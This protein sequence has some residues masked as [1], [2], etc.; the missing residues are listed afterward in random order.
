MTATEKRGALAVATSAKEL[1]NNLKNQAIA[2]GDR[3]GTDI[4]VGAELESRR[5]DMPRAPFIRDMDEVTALPGE[6][7][8]ERYTDLTALQV[9]AE[10]TGSRKHWSEDT[11]L[12]RLSGAVQILKLCVELAYLEGDDLTAELAHDD[13]VSAEWRLR[14]AERG[15]GRG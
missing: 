7:S 10:R 3:G 14:Q 8:A 12:H 2:E 11:N 1:R 9:R 15:G 6:A 13:L 5:P 4:F